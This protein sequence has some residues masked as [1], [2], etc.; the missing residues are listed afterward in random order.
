MNYEEFKQELQEKFQRRVGSRYLVSICEAPLPGKKPEDIMMLFDTEE[1]VLQKTAI[2]PF[3]L[4]CT[5]WKVPMEELVRILYTGFSIPDRDCEIIDTSRIF[6]RLENLE[7]V[8][9]EYDNVPY[10]KFLDLAIVFYT[11]IS[12]SD[13]SIQSERITKH[14]MKEANL[15]LSDLMR[16]ANQNTPKLFPQTLRDLDDV[17]LDMLIQNPDSLDDPEIEFQVMTMFLSDIG[18]LPDSINQKQYMLSCKGGV[19]GST[20][21]LYPNLLKD[22]GDKFQSDF[23]LMPCCKDEVIVEPITET[24][25]LQRLIKTVSDVTTNLLNPKELLSTHVYQYT[26]SDG[27]LKIV[28]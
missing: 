3:Y 26:R 24:S 17:F 23:Y 9:N 27:G 13:T 6:Y 12:M 1:G 15:S 5:K 4:T 8:L 10:Q 25:D 22:I 18:I 7:H 20:A 11:K 21:I 2:A 19:Y 16:F 14:R 28:G